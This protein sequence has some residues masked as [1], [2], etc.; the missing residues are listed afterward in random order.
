MT[1]PERLNARATVHPS[2]HRAPARN[3]EVRLNSDNDRDDTRPKTQNGS[4][5]SHGAGVQSPQAV[6]PRPCKTPP[7]ICRPLKS[8][9]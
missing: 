2:R 1:V 5:F 7:A 6:A 8:H 4:A 3:A 9:R